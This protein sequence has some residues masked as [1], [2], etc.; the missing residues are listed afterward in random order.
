MLQTDL[1]RKERAMGYNISQF[2]QKKKITVEQ[3]AEMVQI[4]KMRIKAILTGSANVQE[5]EVTTF[6]DTLGVD[7]EELLI[8][9]DESMKDYNIHYMGTATNAADMSKILDKVDMYVR[10]VNIQSNK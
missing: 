1:L 7:Q 4:P 2:M 6:A 5:D 8:A 3:L 10:L 9:S